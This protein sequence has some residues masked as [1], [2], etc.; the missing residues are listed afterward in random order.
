MNRVWHVT[1]KEF[2]QVFRDPRM[3][4]IVFVA[5]VVQLFLFGYAVTLDI[6]DIQVTVMDRDQSR[7][8]RDLR[9]ALFHTGYFTDAGA[10]DSE[11]DIE[12]ALRTG[13]AGMAVVIPRGFGDDLA[14]GRTA[15]LQVILDGS[16]SNTASVGMGYLGKIVTAFNREALAAAAGSAAGPGV[17]LESRFL[18]N[19]GLKSSVFFVPGVFGMIL[20][21]ITMILTTLAITREREVGTIEQLVITPIRPWE[22][23]LGK[24]VPFAIIGM[25]DISLILAVGVAHFE[26]PVRGSVPLLFLAAAAFLFSTLGVGL[27]ISTISRTQQQAIFVAFM[28]IMPAVLLSGMM[29]PIENMPVPVQWLTYANPLRYFF[30]IVRG[31]LLKGNGMDVLGG[32][33]LLLFAIGLAVFAFAAYKFR[34]TITQ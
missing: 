9:R 10:A 32:Q 21:V 17:A 16:Q 13:R 22:L 12:A 3:F 26:L 20:L 19:P 29:F 1:I 11:G 24:L 18:Y 34:K 25:I 23:I 2:I 14:C 8:G 27:L 6:H 15:Q 31:I 4:M 7:A 5:P 33:Y 28:F 30:S